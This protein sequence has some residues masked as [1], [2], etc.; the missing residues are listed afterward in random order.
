MD[1]FSEVFDIIRKT[2]EKPF[3]DLHLQ[4]PINI[5][6]WKLRAQ[7]H[8]LNNIRRFSPIKEFIELYGDR[9]TIDED[10]SVR[11]W[12]A[13]MMDYTSNLNPMYPDLK[14]SMP[15]D[16]RQALAQYISCACGAAQKEV[17]QHSLD[18]LNN[19]E[20]GERH[21][22]Q[23][24]YMELGFV[25]RVAVQWKAIQSTKTDASII[26]DRL[27]YA[28]WRTFRKYS[29]LQGIRWSYC[30]DACY[31]KQKENDSD[32]NPTC[33]NRF[34]MLTL[35]KG[36]SFRKG[37]SPWI[38]VPSE[39]L[40]CWADTLESRYLTYLGCL[41]P[42]RCPIEYPSAEVLTRLYRCGDALLLRGGNRGY[43]VIKLLEALC[44]S[45]LQYRLNKKHQIP[46]KDQFYDSILSE[47]KDLGRDLGCMS[48]VELLHDIINSQSDRK[49][50]EIF[51]MYRHW[52]HPFLQVTE[53]LRGI[54][55]NARIPKVI[56]TRL[57]ES[58]ASDCAFVLLK[59]YYSKHQSWPPDC[60]ISYYKSAILS[61]C[62]A[63]NRWP[64]RDEI[65]RIPPV[66]NS[67]N[68]P[69]LN[70]IPDIIP[71]DILIDDKSHSVDKFEMR[72]LLRKAAAGQH[73]SASRRVIVTALESP[74]INI[75][76][77]LRSIDQFGMPD[78]DSLIGLKGKER[79]LKVEGRF[80]SL[81]T[82]KLRLY[83]VATEWLI[84][85]YILPAFKEITMLDSGTELMGKF[86]KMTRGVYDPEKRR[87]LH[88]AIHLDYSKWNA[89]QRFESTAPVFRVLDKALGYT[90]L[91][92][93]THEIFQQCTYYYA[94][95]LFMITSLETENEYC[96]SNHYGGIEGLRQKGW[97]VVG[98]LVL[99]RVSTEFDQ[100]FDIMIQGD[101]QVVVLQYPTEVVPSD[102]EYR[103]EVDRIIRITKLILERI[104]ETARQIGLITKMEETWISCGLMI[105]GK[106]PVLE[107]TACGIL[108]KRLSRMYCLANEKVP[109]LQS[110]LSSIVTAGLTIAQGQ[111]DTI[112]AICLTYYRLYQ[113]V[114]EHRQL[115]LCF[116]APLSNLFK[117]YGSRLYQRLG[118]W[119]NRMNQDELDF[120]ILTRDTVLGGIGGTSP[121]RFM[122]RQF[123]DPLCESLTAIAM[124]C[125][126]VQAPYNR[127]LLIQANPLLDEQRH[128]TN[129]IEDPT[130]LNLKSG[131]NIQTVIKG[132]VDDT[133]AA[134]TNYWIR[135]TSIQE[136][137]RTLHQKSNDLVNSLLQWSPVL[138]NLLSNM[139]EASMLGQARALL[140]RFD[141]T[142]T[143]VD[144]AFQTSA[145]HIHTRLQ[146]AYT[147]SLTV[148]L[149]HHS[150]DDPS[151]DRI[152]CAYKTSLTLQERSW[153]LDLV[154]NRLPHPGEQ[155]HLVPQTEGRCEY[156]LSE[157][158]RREKIILSLSY[159]VLESVKMLNK[160]G[161]SQ[162]YLGKETTMHKATMKQANAKSSDSS[163]R[164][165]LQ[166]T[167]GINWFIAPESTMS[168]TILNL[169]KSVSDYPVDEFPTPPLI[170]SGDVLHRY[171]GS[172]MNRGSFIPTSFTP[173]TN[174]FLNTNT[175]ESL[176]KGKENRLL[177]FQS[178][179]IYYSTVVFNQL[180][181]GV[182]SRPSYHIHVACTDC[183]PLCR[184]V[185]YTGREIPPIVWPSPTEP[186]RSPFYS[187]GGK[188]LITTSPKALLIPTSWR[189]L[190][191]HVQEDNIYLFLGYIVTDSTM[192]LE[193]REFTPDSIFSNTLFRKI[194]Y[195][196]WLDAIRVSFYIRDAIN[197]IYH[198]GGNIV[199]NY[200]SMKQRVIARAIQTRLSP[201]ILRHAHLDNFLGQ[202][203]YHTGTTPSSYPPKTE[204]IHDIIVQD[205]IMHI[206]ESPVEPTS[207][208]QWLFDYPL[209]F[210]PDI[211]QLRVVEE[212]VAGLSLLLYADQHDKK[213]TIVESDRLAAMLNSR[214]P[215]P[216]VQ[217]EVL[218]SV[219][220]ANSLMK[221][222]ISDLRFKDV[223]DDITPA[224]VTAKETEAPLYS[225]KAKEIQIIYNYPDQWV[226]EPKGVRLTTPISQFFRSVGGKTTASIKLASILHYLNPD[227]GCW[228]I[229]GDGGGG[230]TR[231]VLVR[232]LCDQ[233]IFNTLPQMDDIGEQSLGSVIPPAVLDLP[234]EMQ[235]KLIGINRFFNSNQDLT[236]T[237]VYQYWSALLLENTTKDL[238]T[239]L[240]DA[241][242]YDDS[243][244]LVVANNLLQFFNNQPTA[245][246]LVIKAHL[247]Q[248]QRLSTSERILNILRQAVVLRCPHSQWGATEVYLLICKARPNKV[249]NF[250]HL[251]DAMRSHCLVDI[252]TQ[253]Q[254]FK[255][256]F[257]QQ[258]KP[259]SGDWVKR[260][261]C[262]Y[263]T[264]L[265][266]RNQAVIFPRSYSFG[267][268][269]GTMYHWVRYLYTYDLSDSECLEATTPLDRRLHLKDLHNLLGIR[270][271]L[272]CLFYAI[273]GNASA[274]R[275][276]AME[277]TLGKTKYTFH[278]RCKAV[279][280]IV[281]HQI[282]VGSPIHISNWSKKRG[283]Y[284]KIVQILGA[285]VVWNHTNLDLFKKRALADIRECFTKMHVHSHLSE[286][287][288]DVDVYRMIRS[289]W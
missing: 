218:K 278:R 251:E 214:K 136:G 166:V 130:S 96:W 172:R 171:G 274:Y 112:T 154:G 86:A 7:K 122:V 100:P 239:L 283:S 68:H 126:R 194:N 216:W 242:T 41:L 18:I 67:I 25:L 138:P 196:K 220:V 179:F 70:D 246:Q 44:L 281:K 95:A 11:T 192:F 200:T 213:S 83:F 259:L 50:L 267:Y 75:A 82:F 6:H 119:Q 288:G 158:L 178:V 222:R 198:V 103:A 27:R 286:L 144:K 59:H 85:K 123:P 161:P 233:V 110:S 20:D 265:D 153:G 173:A 118:K 207:W 135:N 279:D 101:N 237:A 117:S 51:G 22:V 49:I 228:I 170:L 210:F 140:N 76:E 230:F 209:C 143:L 46:L 23:S 157:G 289:N 285:A 90:N 125:D 30:C 81:M 61:R 8:G 241:E 205:I 280:I 287:K 276:A 104:C 167:E 69:A 105:Y 248:L 147:K 187:K 124:S 245:T 261:W 109:T 191:K 53:G 284:R 128:Y 145:G 132:I 152:N 5:E 127:V 15:V 169:L 180:I 94:D 47:L 212:M 199:I 72:S 164:K 19:L 73:V 176:G 202:V 45:T 229:C 54:K 184:E 58:L 203:L 193:H 34:E 137:L 139:M 1:Y 244:W 80:F 163:I 277:W 106:Y 24:K 264:S 14:R 270:C 88:F 9:Y 39:F 38:V 12:V 208:L 134:P 206:A 111:P 269:W 16:M 256:M 98:A 32:F 13:F 266:V 66:W 272:E 52:G 215:V 97:S 93:R 231:E 121:I 165:V 155:F 249:G 113:V 217:S 108:S 226:R 190:P 232:D 57:M 263:T 102:I 253:L 174:V 84:G 4:G 28:G 195:L 250:L 26:E 188:Y 115:D 33:A 35:E 29:G 204:E 201:V 238:T 168:E 146:K 79:E 273:I 40:L 223:V 181:A 43:N 63:R 107:G 186:S 62:I 133:L 255:D 252:L 42:A 236:K 247:I 175:L 37:N 48:D 160:P 36:F 275:E 141:G 254:A 148:F 149:E 183:L 89:H 116:R 151:I 271:A 159:P 56:N 243:S 142:R 162:P 10:T 129:L 235:K 31:R 234:F 150:T 55:K 224:V 282:P 64:T 221:C 120:D 60:N 3:P 131:S 71:V 185:L 189:S 91:I 268:L 74:N 92:T 225:I 17:Y 260:E 182:C 99:R 21:P 77:T 240:C 258:I 219:E 78:N 156:C 2:G 197:L 257:S 65:R 177:L 87:T 211:S 227:R 114:Q 262:R